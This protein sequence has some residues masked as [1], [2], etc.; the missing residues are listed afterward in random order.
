MPEPIM[1]ISKHTA[2]GLMAR[3][4]LKKSSDTTS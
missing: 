4:L 1:A 3:R 2:T